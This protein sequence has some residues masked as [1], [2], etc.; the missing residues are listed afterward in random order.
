MKAAEEALKQT[1]ITQPAMPDD[2][3]RPRTRSS[4]A[5][6]FEPDLVM[7]HSLGEYAALVA[8]G[9]MP[10]ADA[11][12]AAAARGAR[13]DARLPRRQRRRWR[14]S[15]RRSRRSRRSSRT[16][17]RLRRR[18]E[19]QQ[20]GPVRHRRRVARG[21]S[22]GRRASEEG[23]SRHPP[24][25]QP[26][27]PHARSWRRRARRSGRSSTASGS[28]P[29]KRKL[30]ANVT[31]GLYPETVDGI[32]ETLQKQIASPVQWVQGL[33]TLWAE[34][35]RTF[36]EV[37]PKQALKGFVDDVLDGRPGPRLALHE[38]AEARRRRPR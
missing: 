10:F 7:G 2:R 28:S 9:V 24:P 29:P 1:A 23:L 16:D 37:G 14:R 17:R 35:A 38:R 21:G 34:G 3:R 22:G 20:P 15:W 18:G 13:D 27:L 30:V 8:A 4:G 32:K 36:V 11:L 33:E 26:R 6:G 31:G 12:E 5:Y 19:H 25:G